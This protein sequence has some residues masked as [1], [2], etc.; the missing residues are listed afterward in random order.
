MPESPESSP[1]AEMA[2]AEAWCR[3]LP[4]DLRDW[5]IA[6]AE[7]RRLGAGQRLF[8]RGDPPDGLYALAAGT[9]RI[10]GLTPEGREALL[11]MLDAP[12]WFGEIALL[13]GEPRTHDAWAE[14][15]AGL[16]HVPQAALHQRLQQCPQDWRHFGRLLAQKLR[17]LFTTVEETAL[18]PP[19][20]R[21]AR[22]LATMAG[23]YG[24]WTDRSARVVRVSQEQLALM[25]ALSRQ[26]V[27][28]SLRDL[29]A[30]GAIRR[31]RGA[32]EILTPER[33]LEPGA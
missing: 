29:E 10:T 1:L 28:Q 25:L 21:V 7:V 19:T 2:R 3:S 30:A 8:A 23:G 12:H 27:N 15:D 11:A 24:A 14:T 16:L 5:L 33:L 9:I 31:T 32:I 13:D 26:T 4:Q 17:V 22:R 20:A 18:L 6:H